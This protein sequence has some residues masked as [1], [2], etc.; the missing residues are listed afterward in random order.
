MFGGFDMNSN[1]DTAPP[2]GGSNAIPAGKTPPGT[3]VSFNH[4]IKRIINREN[5]Q[6]AKLHHNIL[7]E[8][9]TK[10]KSYIS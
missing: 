7:H 4:Q 6:W 1:D 3:I 8:K 9:G 10:V 5:E 2:G